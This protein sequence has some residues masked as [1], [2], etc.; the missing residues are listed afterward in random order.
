MTRGY[1]WLIAGSLLGLT[2]AYMGLAANS[3]RRRVKRSARR[4][5]AKMTSRVSRE[6][7]N[8]IA[9][10]GENLANTLR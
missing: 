3:G 4:S 10:M 5:M 2:G 7:G 6:A 9:T 1:R 8:A